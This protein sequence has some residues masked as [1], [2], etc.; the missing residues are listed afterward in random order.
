MRERAMRDLAVCK[1]TCLWRKNRGGL[2]L[3][4]RQLVERL[5]PYLTQA[6]FDFE[7]I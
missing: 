1:W 4:A 2:P 7:A 3:T 5:L 6:D